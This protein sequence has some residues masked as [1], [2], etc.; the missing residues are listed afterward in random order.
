MRKKLLFALFAMLALFVAVGLSLPSRYHVE[1]SIAIG[2]PAATI[3][4][5]LNS[6]RAFNA[7]S[8]WAE[9]DP[10]AIYTLAGPVSGIGARLEWAGDPRL[11]GTGWQEITDSRPF[12]RIDMHLDFST[13][14]AAKGYFVLD[15]GAGAVQVTWAIDMDMTRGRSLFGALLGRYFGLFFD[16]WIGTKYEQGLTRLKA[17]AEALPPA[18]FANAEIALLDVIPVPVIYVAGPG[19][20]GVDA[21]AALAAAY[22]EI[23][24][25]LA[26]N[27]LKAE[28]Q[29]MAI[30]RGRNASEYR[31]EAAVPATA[32]AEL[33]AGG[34]KSG[35]SPGGRAA[36]IVH[37]GSYAGLPAAYSRLQAYMAA[38][39]LRA[40]PVSWE[41]Y[42]SDPVHTPT[43]E[44]VSHIYIQVDE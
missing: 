27:A 4:T 25:F 43:D 31:F 32:P 13:Q 2:R 26:A 18:D 38:H 9:R 6:F 3:F 30:T 15:E 35:L 28:G 16:R 7:W 22:T 39:G 1:R 23:T 41:H 10:A 36:R 14:G 20:Q 12:E 8:P 21:A 33:L 42:I 29:P 19:S 17:Y 11:V 34:L 24:A 44:V 37:R 5:I 40:G